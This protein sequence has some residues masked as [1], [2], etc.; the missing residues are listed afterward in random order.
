M[1]I[2]WKITEKYSMKQST[3]IQ[4][5][6]GLEPLLIWLLHTSKQ[7]R[8]WATFTLKDKFRTTEFTQNFWTC[9]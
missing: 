9:K 3:W 8:D 6:E 4:Q 7:R 1:M 2:L 5:T